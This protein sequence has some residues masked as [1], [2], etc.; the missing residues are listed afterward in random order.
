MDHFILPSLIDTLT[1]W[2]EPTRLAVAVGGATMEGGGSTGGPALSA[3]PHVMEGQV[4]GS[5]LGSRSRGMTADSVRMATS[6]LDSA[7][8]ASG[9]PRQ[10]MDS[11]GGFG[12]GGQ[13]HLARAL[14]AGAGRGEVD[15]GAV[16]AAPPPY[17]TA[18]PA[19]VALFGV[20][21]L[22]LAVKHPPLVK[23]TLAALLTPSKEATTADGGGFAGG[24]GGGGGG[25]DG[26]ISS[27]TD[28]GAEAKAAAAAAAA[29][30]VEIR[31]SM[32]ASFKAGG[33][34]SHLKLLGDPANPCPLTPCLPYL[35]GRAG[36]GP[37]ARGLFGVPHTNAPLDASDAERPHGAHSR[38][39]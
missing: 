28:L 8:L 27:A 34:V 10:A 16:T 1:A 37:R 15:G 24:S 25:G 21:Q 17:E 33:D 3:L 39:N 2:H 14:G 5:G 22:L 19:A 6:E 4:L 11:E 38:C 31:E 32:R 20:A 7:A 26:D 30:T 9:H 23:A 35:P 13:A 36:R 29:V 18:A 12:E